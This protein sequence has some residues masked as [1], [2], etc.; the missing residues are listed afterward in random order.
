MHC[1]KGAVPSL[2]AEVWKSCG[3][4]TGGAGTVAAHWAMD[5]HGLMHISTADANLQQYLCT[6]LSNAIAAGE[7]GIGCMAGVKLNTVSS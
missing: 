5:A 6:L 3:V 7:H 4:V 2:H 1:Y